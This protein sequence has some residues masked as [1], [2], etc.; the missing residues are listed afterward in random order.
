MI[1]KTNPSRFYYIEE[2]RIKKWEKYIDTRT[3]QAG[4]AW[5]S[6]GYGMRG[7]HL[8][9]V[10]AATATGSW[11]WCAQCSTPVCVC[12]RALVTDTSPPL[13]GSWERYAYIPTGY[14]VFGHHPRR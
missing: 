3:C 8:E 12:R 14:G 2:E 6:K 4:F 1:Q 9:G 7:R 11:R 5:L 13:A 10:M